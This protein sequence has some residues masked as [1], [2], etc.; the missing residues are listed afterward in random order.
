MKKVTI[1]LLLMFMFIL[2]SNNAKA[3]DCNIPYGVWTHVEADMFGT[4]IP[5][6]EKSTIIRIGKNI[7]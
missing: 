5:V 6:S 7:L 2:G 1:T 3:E 4:S